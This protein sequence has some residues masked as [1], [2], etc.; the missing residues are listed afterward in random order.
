M[1]WLLNLE[2]IAICCFYAEP[3]TVRWKIEEVT[4]TGI[5]LSHFQ[6]LCQWVWCVLYGSGSRAFFF[7]FS[8]PRRDG[9]NL[10]NTGIC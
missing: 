6:L 4:L 10:P 2:P 8:F 3:L 9:G 5:P 1:W 7:F